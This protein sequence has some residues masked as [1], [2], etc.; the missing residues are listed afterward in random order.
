MNLARWHQ[1]ETLYNRA[2]EM[3]GAQRTA[4]LREACVGDLDL[5]RDIEELFAEESQAGS[6]LEEPALK[7]FA[8]EFAAH[9]APWAGRRI[10]N[11]QFVSMIGAGGMG[12]VYRAR[13]TRLEREVAIKILPEDFSNDPERVSRFRREAQLLASLNHPNIAAIYDLEEE[14]G[15]LFLILELVEG[16][17][18][19]ERLRR[20]PIAPDEAMQ[21]A[22]Q[23]A[24]GLEAAHESGII[25]RDLKPA[26]V[27]V[28]VEGVVKVLDFGLAEALTHEPVPKDLGSSSPISG[29]ST[30]QGVI[31]G[32][33]TYMSPE[34]AKGRAVDRRADIWAFGVLLYELLTGKHAFRGA[35]AD[36]ILAGIVMTEPAHDMLPTTTPTAIR[37]L[38]CRCLEKNPKR[39]LQHIGEARI[40]IEDALSGDA[41]AAPVAVHPTGRKWLAWTAMAAIVSIAIGF[42]VGY[43]LR[44]PKPLPPMR[45]SVEIEGSLFTT[46][47]ASSVLSPDGALLA[48][49]ATGADNKRRIYLHP[50]DGPQATTPISGTE[51]ARNPF[52]SPDSQGLGFFADGKLKTLSVQSSA[53]S[54]L[55]PAP[56]DRGGSWGEDDTIVFAESQVA[57]LSKV[58]VSS[59]AGTPEP[60]TTLDEN[61]GEGTHRWPQILPG[62]DV[63]FTANSRTND[64]ED[65]KIVVYSRASGQRKTVLHG[66]YYARYLPSGHLVYAHEGALLAVA[67]DLHRLEV[68]GQ[69]TILEGVMSNPASGGAQFSFSENGHLAYLEGRVGPRKVFIDW[70][71]RGGTMA[72]LLKTPGDYFNP[73]FS[74]DG[75]RLALDISADGR[76]D[77][78]VYE[79]ERDDIK[80]LTTFA[81]ETNGYPVWTPNGE[82]I[83]YSSQ[84]KNAGHSQYSLWWIRADG[85]GDA[86]RLAESESLPYTP[87][88]HPDGKVLA[89]RQS[90]VKTGWDI[91]TLTIEGDE[92]SGWKPGK[93]KPFINSASDER[94]PAF[95][96]DGR[97]LAYVSN[98]LG[99]YDVYVR[100]FPGPGGERQISSGGGNFPKWSL[101][102]KE[103]LYMKAGKIMVVAYTASSDSFRFDKP[104]VLV[105]GAVWRHFSPG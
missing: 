6:F 89:F 54:V 40:L 98:K 3:D 17:T 32:T 65:S 9:A 11:Y 27:K 96:P 74:P 34:Q 85:A 84:D 19:A 73:T 72:P 61:T 58:K 82:R 105:V 101:D 44:A 102:G 13:D 87:T 21:I 59:T 91:M 26:N 56:D 42:A 31:L 23:I 68:Y 103:L 41:S 15:S 7:E 90:N 4:F 76:K 1:I 29:T 79:W 49:V 52:F 67:F 75:K 60:F 71:D 70:M 35:D 12:E 50:M 99:D 16:E 45:V 14:G 77:V 24:E 33:P 18:L 5:Q 63:L 10:G 94:T 47:G 83:V 51:N 53:V 43:A 2:L 69:P 20:G 78:W 46:Y 93:P 97:W 62:G 8:G 95:S 80:R 57:A 81:G 48:L 88:W 104:Q 30:R 55:C 86:Q 37:N 38:L 36:E 66:G 64:Y 100:P 28:T 92:K 22:I 25:H 39:R